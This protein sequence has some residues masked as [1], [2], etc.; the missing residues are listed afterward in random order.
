M[1][2]ALSPPQYGGTAGARAGLITCL[3][4]VS[5]VKYVSPRANGLHGQWL[6]LKCH[7][8]GDLL[9]GPGKYSRLMVSSMLTMLILIDLVALQKILHVSEDGSAYGRG[10][11]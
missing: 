9:L 6:K 11:R 1:R 4:T 7:T 3:P 10:T 2:R 5:G 8:P